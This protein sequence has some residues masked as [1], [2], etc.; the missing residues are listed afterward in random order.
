MTVSRI[1][2]NKAELDSLIA[3]LGARKLPITV[4]VK[5][6][7]HRTNNQNSLQRKWL[8]EAAQQLGDETAEEKRG[9]CKLH[10]GVPIL[11]NES[12]EFRAE[13]DDVIRPLSYEHKLKLMQDPFD[14]RVT[15]LMNTKQK[16]QYL[17][18]VH[19]HFTA[20]GVQ[21]T[22]PEAQR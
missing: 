3:L 22:N 17:D 9:Y 6:G 19:Q 2:T 20:Q 14:F 4:A 5:D 13:Y 21:L 15:S 16:K 12:A 8:V 11:R 1:I 18:A 10:F 7:K